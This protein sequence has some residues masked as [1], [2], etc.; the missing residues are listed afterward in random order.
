M[1]RKITVI[2]GVLFGCEYN[3]H[4]WIWYP[5]LRHLYASVDLAVCSR[6]T[7]VELG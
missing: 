7:A 1:M 3:D 5:E 6:Q 4:I 2:P